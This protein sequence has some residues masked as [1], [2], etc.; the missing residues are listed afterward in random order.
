MEL[1]TG[2]APASGD[3]LGFIVVDY[4]QLMQGTRTDNR[5]QEVSDILPGPESPWR[6][7]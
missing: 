7:S 5:V 6:G 1:R 2:P 4:L 3:D